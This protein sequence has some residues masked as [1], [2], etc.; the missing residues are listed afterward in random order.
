MIFI[1]TKVSKRNIDGLFPG[2]AVGPGLWSSCNVLPTC[3]YDVR[4][5][6]RGYASVRLPGVLHM[7]VGHSKFGDSTF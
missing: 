5:S 6:Y 1:V 7:N 3:C 4:T 2:V